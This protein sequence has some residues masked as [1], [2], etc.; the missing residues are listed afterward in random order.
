MTRMHDPAARAATIAEAADSIIE[1]DVC[2]GQL[3]T[4]ASVVKGTAD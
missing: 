2:T 1:T 3:D 4:S